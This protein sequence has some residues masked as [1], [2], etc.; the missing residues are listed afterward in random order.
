MPELALNNPL[1]R[2]DMLRKR[3]QNGAQLVATELADEFDIS[4]DTIRRDLLVLEEKGYAQRVRGGAVPSAQPLQSLKQRRERPGRNVSHLAEAAVPLI[5]EGM[6]ILMDGGT[7]LEKLA[8]RLQPS[9]GL[10]V[11]TP[12][13]VIAT[14]LIHKDI[15]VHLIGGRISPWGGVAVGREAE[16]ALSEMAVDLAFLGV[17]GLEATFGLS[18]DDSDEAAMKQAMAKAAR[19]TALICRN[20]KVGHRARHRV[21]EPEHLSTIIT[22]ADPDAMRAFSETGAE[23]IHV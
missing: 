1:V 14:L 3:L 9:P 17:C 13:P 21:L 16:R 6:S 4:L 22:D 8:E 18:A 10:L 12:S 23:I 7:T 5:K 19:N 2:Q 11:V 20:E 15:T